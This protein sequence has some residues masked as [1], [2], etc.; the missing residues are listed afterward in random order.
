MVLGGVATICERVEDVKHRSAYVIATDYHPD[1]P[2]KKIVDETWMVNT[3]DVEILAQKCIAAE[4]GGVDS[5]S[6]EFNDVCS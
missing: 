1:S 4:V 5:T 3:P 6:T 2:T